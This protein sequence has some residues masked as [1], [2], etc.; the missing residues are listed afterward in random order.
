M[1]SKIQI[2][3]RLYKINKAIREL[4]KTNEKFKKKYEE[5]NFFYKRQ[6][7]IKLLNREKTV[8]KWVLNER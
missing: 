1:K 3:F 2:R 7:D 6:E 5:P 8:L 4:E